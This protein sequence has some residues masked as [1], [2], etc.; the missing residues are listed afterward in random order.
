M[1]NY[2]RFHGLGWDQ[3]GRCLSDASV[4]HPQ[5]DPIPK[6]RPRDVLGGLLEV[7]LPDDIMDRNDVWLAKE[8]A[9]PS[10]VLI[11]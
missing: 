1:R 6:P 11:R 5:V 8:Q 10:E 3:D 9:V 7:Q 4:V 2:I